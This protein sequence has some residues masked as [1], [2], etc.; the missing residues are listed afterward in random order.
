M[1][2]ICCFL[3]ITIADGYMYSIVSL[4]ESGVYVDGVV[5][6]LCC[7][8]LRCVNVYGYATI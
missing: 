6:Y 8:F 3:E 5:G 7:C 1:H 2:M 4:V